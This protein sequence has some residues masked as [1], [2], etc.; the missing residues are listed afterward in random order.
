MRLA[1]VGPCVCLQSQG[2][3]F[4]QALVNEIRMRCRSGHL[5]CGPK[6]VMPKGLT[7]HAQAFSFPLPSSFDYSGVSARHFSAPAYCDPAQPRKRVLAP[8]LY[9]C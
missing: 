6:P 3:A 8:G 4:W 2:T 9:G 7:A 1:S 5:Y